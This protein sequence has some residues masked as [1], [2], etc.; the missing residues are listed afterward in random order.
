MSAS[1][2]AIDLSASLV[3][4]VHAVDVAPQRSISFDG[5]PADQR[6][7]NNDELLPREQALQELRLLEAAVAR[8]SLLSFTSYTFP[9]FVPYWHHQRI[10]AKL[11]DVIA[12]RS[13]RVMFFM[14]PQHGKTELCSRRF[15]AY[16]LGKDPDLRIISGTYNAERAAEVSGEVQR[17]ID[18]PE[19]RA[20]FPGTRL[21]SGK[22]IERRQA[23][24]FDIVGRSGY[25]I[26]AG[27]GQ[28]IAG[29]SMNIGIIDDPFKN[30]E[31][32]DSEII[33]R[34]VWE[35]WVNDFSRR[36]VDAD[37]RI[38]LI[39]TRWHEDDLAGHLLHLAKHTPYADQWEVVCFPA[40]LEE[41]TPGD[42]RQLGDALWPERF[43]RAFLDATK[44]QGIYEWS[45]L[46][47]Q[48]PVPAGGALAQRTWFPV[49]AYP[50]PNGM[51]VRRC[52][53]WDLAA[54]VPKPGKDPDWTVGTRLAQ[55]TDGRW[56]VEDVVRVR[57][58]PAEVEKVILQTA[59]MDSRYTII[60]EEQEG[61]SAGKAVISAHTKLLA[62]Y[63]YAG[64]PA[65]KEKATRW[66]PFLAQAEGGYVALNP[67]NWNTPW[68]DELVTVPYGRHDDCADSVALAFNTLTEVKDYGSSVAAIMPLHTT[69][70][71]RQWS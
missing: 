61:G 25:Y 43:P 71:R 6:Y 22:D 4:H 1:T 38:I 29:K 70:W 20:L 47:Q 2:R 28:G 14:P 59:R 45:A 16:L 56:I 13:R 32:A 52:R 53:A 33:R 27:V 5:V 55:L 3:E 36:Q 62:G 58:T 17:I 10:A 57:T 35:W 50:I 24:K 19:Y 63:D 21:A 64:V 9:K 68:L 26:A 67:G 39:Q 46:Y 11:E 60:R 51:V 23:Q 37:S 7:T 40:V 12:G 31:E 18:S 8:R 41:L 34:R 65:H 15:V 48:S 49:L 54:T 30:R 66:R 42:P 69:D 44:S